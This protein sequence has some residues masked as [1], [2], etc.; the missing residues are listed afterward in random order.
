MNHRWFKG[1]RQS[2]GNYIFREDDCDCG[3]VRRM[4]LN[5]Q[6]KEEVEFYQ[7]KEDITVA[8]PTCTKQKRKKYKIF[9]NGYMAECPKL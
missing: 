2:Y 1:V 3:C 5:D 6:N 9:T 4:V 8:E 7:I